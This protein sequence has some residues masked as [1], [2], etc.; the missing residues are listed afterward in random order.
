[1]KHS[2]RVARIAPSVT[3]AITQCFALWS[4]ASKSYPASS[5]S[6][7]ARCGTWRSET[8]DKVASSATQTSS[9]LS[10]AS[11][12]WWAPPTSSMCLSA[13]VRNPQPSTQAGSIDVKMTFSWSFTRSKASL[14]AL[15]ATW[16]FMSTRDACLRSG[17]RTSFFGARTSS[18]RWSRSLCWS[19]TT[20]RTRQWWHWVSSI[21]SATLSSSFSWSRLKDAL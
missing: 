20:L 3:V 1:M 2:M 16:W 8:L 17:M 9:S 14:G 10:S 7:L 6:S 11:Q 21:W 18:S 19:K 12:V 4:S 13:G 5:F 15:V